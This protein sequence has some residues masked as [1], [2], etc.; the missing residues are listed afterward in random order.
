MSDTDMYKHHHR[1]SKTLGSVVFTSEHTKGGHFAAFEQPDLLTN[2]IRK[3]FGIG[4]PAFG[5]VPGKSGYAA[6]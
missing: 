3:M 6:K 2:D 1:W 4:G 5:V